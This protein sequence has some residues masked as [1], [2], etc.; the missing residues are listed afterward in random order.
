MARSSAG[1]TTDDLTIDVHLHDDWMHR[2]IREDVRAGLLAVPKELPP[3]WF[4]DDIGSGLF[5]EITRLD[6]YYPTEAE[7]E[8]L[9]READNIAML[10]GAEV[11]IEL[12][13]GTSDKTTAV[14]D[15]LTATGQLEM[16]V[17]F[18]VS[19]AT[20]RDAAHSVVGRY[21]GLAVHAVVGDFEHH[22][23]HLPSGGRRL[24]A[25]FG[26][27]IGNFEPR[28]RAEFL[29]AIAAQ[30]DPGDS[31]LLG[32]DLVKD[33]RRL[34][35]A[36]D[37]SLGVTA[38]FNK[39]V[40][41]VINRELGA[42]FDLERFEHVAHFDSHDEWIEMRLRSMVDQTVVIDELDLVV[43]FA[44]GEEMRTEI[45]AKFRPER[46]ASELD[47]AGFDLAQFWTDRAGDYALS[48]AF[49]R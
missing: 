7:R 49:R 45:S 44:A 29:C 4:Y 48:L 43:P 30:L 34:E 11:F 25:L 18:D 3:K 42:D 10:S 1:S 33:H 37:D 23:G 2:A 38:A 47:A 21:P 15:A 16:F 46:V 12:G 40:L 6:E 31:L 9:H 22:L 19:E 41:A 17:P 35:R 13:S 24:V 26:G 36:Y 8:I 5:D 14:L 27:T 39:N 32:T 20:L 28:S